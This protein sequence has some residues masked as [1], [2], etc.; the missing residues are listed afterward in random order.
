[1][2]P[3]G[4]VESTKFRE[5]HRFVGRQIKKLRSRWPKIFV[6]VLRL[7]IYIEWTCLLERQGFQGLNSSNSTDVHLHL[8]MT[9]S[10]VQLVRL[11]ILGASHASFL[12]TSELG[13]GRRA[14]PRIGRWPRSEDAWLL[15]Y[16]LLQITRCGR[17]H[18]PKKVAN[19]WITKCQSYLWA[20][21]LAALLLAF[22]KL[23]M[24]MIRPFAVFFCRTVFEK[25]S[26]LSFTFSLWPEWHAVGLSVFASKLVA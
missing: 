3:G 6:S 1:M 21:V 14:R 8:L 4:F 20:E 23:C 22:I 7:E 9:R 25:K 2:V 19:L 15:V 11:R 24:N 17:I 13:F 18:L 10:C 5:I 16:L 26:L 12:V